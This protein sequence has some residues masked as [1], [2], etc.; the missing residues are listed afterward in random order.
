MRLPEI[1]VPYGSVEVAID[2][3]IENI[4]ESIEKAVR[5]ITEDETKQKL[6]QINFAGKVGILVADDYE[7]CLKAAAIVG[8]MLLEKNYNSADIQFLVPHRSVTSVR[9]KLEALPF[10]VSTAQ[11]AEGKPIS[12]VYGEATT[13][14]LL[15][16]VGFDGL[17][18]FSGGLISIL[19]AIESL[20]I[21]NSFLTYPILEPSVGT[22]TEASKMVWENANQL[23]D[24]LSI[25]V[26]PS[27][28]DINDVEIGDMLDS[29]KKAE[30]KFLA[31]STKTVAEKARAAI[32]S[33]G[34]NRAS[35]TLS[36][37]VKSF[38]NI[39][40]GLRDKSTVV[41]LAECGEGL[42]V[43]AFKLYGTGRLDSANLPR[44]GK[45][46]EGIED[47]VFL[48]EIAK[49]H[50]LI[51]V[52]TLPNYYIESKFGLKSAK[53]AS[54]ALNH[55]LSSKGSRTKALIVPQASE[56]LLKV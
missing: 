45:Y 17:F 16:Q 46:I 18:G 32:I 48:Q 34:S 54:D 47:L 11:V 7:P 44:L 35:E 15:S 19:R 53:K 1:W 55:L 27:Q 50:E 24:V 2:I 31:L 43:D 20:V 26:V 14:I 8:K 40:K 30:E 10:R 3:R 5:P 51:L 41:L 9:K 36:S 38:W 4:L 13:K 29:Q 49:A 33:P 52:S 21:G 23:T 28:E 42:G 39:L 37:S 22:Y 6:S 25:S 12:E 56:T